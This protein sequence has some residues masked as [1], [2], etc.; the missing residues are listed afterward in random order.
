MREAGDTNVSLAGGWVRR[1]VLL[2]C[3]YFGWNK[4]R[5]GNTLNSPFFKVLVTVAQIS[6]IFWSITLETLGLTF[7]DQIDEDF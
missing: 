7:A 2:M 1:P 5:T 6:L 4:L 3:G